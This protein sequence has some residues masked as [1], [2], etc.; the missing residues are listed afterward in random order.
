MTEEQIARSSKVEDWQRLV[1]AFKQC[2]SS[3]HGQTVMNY[4]SYQC[5]EKRNTFDDKNETRSHRNLGRREIILLIREWMSQDPTKI[6]AN[7]K[8]I[9]IE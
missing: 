9:K 1:I 4:L 6:P 7:L 2:F 8:E 3:E 5:Y